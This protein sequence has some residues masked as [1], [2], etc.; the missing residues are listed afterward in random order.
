MTIDL[1]E[2]TDGTQASRN[3]VELILHQLDQLPTLPHVAVRLIALA[4]SD[5][6]SVSEVAALIETDPSLSARLLK[7]LRLAEYGI[8]TKNLSIA[9]AV[10]LLGFKAVRNIALSAQIFSSIPTPGDRSSEK[11]REALWKHCL[12][13]ACTAEMLAEASGDLVL[14][15]YAFLGGLLHDIGKIALD[16]IAPKSYARVIEQT[17]NHVCIC[18]AE[19]AVFGL[20]HTTAGKHLMTAWQLPRPIIECVWLHHQSPALLPSVAKHRRLVQIIHIAD[21]HVRQQ[22]IGFSGYGNPHDAFALAETLGIRRERFDKIVASLPER[23]EPFCQLIGLDNTNARALYMES[24][25][26]ANRELGRLNLSI[27]ETNRKLST[28][29]RCFDAQHSFTKGLSDNAHLADVCAGAGQALAQAI[30]QND[31]LTFIGLPNSNCLFVNLSSDDPNASNTDIVDVAAS[32]LASELMGLATTQPTVGMM[33]AATD[34]AKAFWRSYISDQTN[35]LPD[36]LPNQSH[37]QSPNQPLWIF[38][39][40]LGSDQI[41]AAI[42]PAES[43]DIAKLEP[44]DPGWSALAEA[45]SVAAKSACT[46]QALETTTDELLEINRRLESAQ[47]DLARDRSVAMVAQ[48]AAGAA[49]EINNPLAVISGR[50]QILLSQELPQESAKSLRSI[51]EQCQNV[52]GIVNDLISFAKPVSPMLAKF[53]LAELLDT[54]CQH[55]QG[56]FVPEQLSLIDCTLA[57]KQLCAY[58]DPD[59]FMEIVLAIADNALRACEENAGRV[60]INSPSC[61]SDETV[62]IVVEDRGIGMTPEVLEHAVDPFYSHRSAGRGRGLGLSRAYRLAENNG[63]KLWLTSTLG[64]GTTVTIELPA[65]A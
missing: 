43:D 10:S 37:N 55:W 26:A 64:I 23:M 24:L 47:K 1:I 14:Q 3:Q 29:V 44:S 6:S 51:V 60:H 2:K 45:L 49:H 12:A 5:V 11:R 16:A 30:G 18:D 56:R 15:G 52:T 54:Q 8:N 9:R 38:T 27:E 32:P 61:L 57:D 34:S 62:R 22:Q 50:A 21:N 41:G 17:N 48:M 4:S 28:R 19:Q 36:A 33:H 46:R 13:V 58:A 59:Q 42:F 35:K 65:R 7:M 25:V 20:S 63:G 31:M 40:L 39:F 53:R